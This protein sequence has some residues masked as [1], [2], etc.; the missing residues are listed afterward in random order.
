M[1]CEI[2]PASLWIGSFGVPYSFYYEG[3]EGEREMASL[4]VTHFS[5]TALVHE[6][7]QKN[8][9]H[10]LSQSQLVS[11][12]LRRMGCVFL[13]ECVFLASLLTMPPLCVVMEW[14][15]R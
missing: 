7:N 14:W 2:I 4:S 6:Y 15:W 1:V 5:H 9:I 12:Y 11:D 10:C 3:R 13:S 8:N